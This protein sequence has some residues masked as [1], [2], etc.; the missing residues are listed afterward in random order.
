MGK[1]PL[2][3]PGGERLWLRLEG[4]PRQA[5][6]TAEGIV[7]D[8]A[9]ASQAPTIGSNHFLVEADSGGHDARN[10]RY[11]SPAPP[12]AGGGFLTFICVSLYI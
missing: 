1:V 9:P 8:L 10:L 4:E 12:S 6:G 11:P 2:S 5:V 3:A 7:A